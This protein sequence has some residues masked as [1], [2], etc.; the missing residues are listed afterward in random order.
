MVKD[1]SEIF[2]AIPLSAGVLY[3]LGV[4][5]SPAMAAVLMSLS[6]VIVAFNARFLKVVK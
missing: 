5:F 6:T 3:G 4:L 1:E 2:P